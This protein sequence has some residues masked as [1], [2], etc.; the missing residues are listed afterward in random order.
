MA[1]TKLTAPNGAAVSVDS[2]KVDGLLRRG[3]TKA[4]G[5]TDTAK[6]PAKK[7][8]AKKSSK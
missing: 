2:E 1:A 8:A 7:S 5:S 6:A 4:G 3:F